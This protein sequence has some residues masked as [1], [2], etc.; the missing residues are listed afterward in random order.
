MTKL[1]SLSKDILRLTKAEIVLLEV[2]TLAAGYFIGHPLERPVDWLKFSVT[3]LGVGALALGSGALNQIQ[4]HTEDAL[5][6]RTR[7][8]PIP[9]GR[10][11]LPLAWGIS[12][13]LFAAGI[14]LLSLVS[15]PVLILGVIAVI[16][17]NGLYTLWWKRRF[18][19][20]AIPGA[21]PGSLPILIG[22]Q[23][24]VANLYDLRGY[25][26]FAILFFWQMPHFWVLALKY[27][28]DYDKG[29]FPTLPVA[30]GSEVTRF[31]ITLWCL[32]YS[33]L[34]LLSTLFFPTGIPGLIG[35]LFTSAW[36]LFELA[37]FLRH[38]EQNTWLRFFLSINFSLLLYLFVISADLWSILLHPKS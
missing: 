19:F 8:R 37:R 18:A 33:A 30:K 2:I 15:I 1:K 17:Y 36:L 20:A 35:T 13:L 31:Q 6:E 34:G 5:M 22:F 38:P 26:L 24:A 7:N 21:I 11:S 12:I 3:F 27:S 10:V 32:A 16:S 28:R 23:A 14:L 4:E 29:G 25:Y 9:S